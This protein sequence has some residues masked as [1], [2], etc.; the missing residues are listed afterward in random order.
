MICCCHQSWGIRN[1]PADQYSVFI[2]AYIVV[3]G[4]YVG[5]CQFMVLEEQVLLGWNQLY[6]LDEQGL[7]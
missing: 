1:N 4:I 6:A 3:F 5:L 2:A 7:V